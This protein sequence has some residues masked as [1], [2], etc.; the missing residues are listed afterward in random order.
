LLVLFFILDVALT[1]VTPALTFT[2]SSAR[3]A[4][5]IGVTMLR[6]FWPA[7]APYALMPALIFIL[8]A[9][10]FLG[11]FIGAGGALVATALAGLLSLALKGATVAFYLRHL[12]APRN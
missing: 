9:Q 7:S 11:P 2:T 10:A 4:F 3:G 6:V 8:G 1:F 12:P 5:S